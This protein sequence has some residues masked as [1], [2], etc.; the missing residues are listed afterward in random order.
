MINLKEFIEVTALYDGKKA[1]IRVACIDSV[2]DNSEQKMEYG[3]KP[4]CRTINYGGYSI[5]VIDSYDDICEKIYQ[6]EL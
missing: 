5:D 2:I 6:A 3:V 1:A 4:A